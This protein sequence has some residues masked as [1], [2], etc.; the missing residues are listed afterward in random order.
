MP[1][2]EYSAM[3]ANVLGLFFLG[4]LSGCKERIA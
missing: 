2:T 1:N 4:F 3:I